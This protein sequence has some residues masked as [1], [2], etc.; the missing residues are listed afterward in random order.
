MFWVGEY[1]YF[2]WIFDFK[3]YLSGEGIIVLR[4]IYKVVLVGV[5]VI[6]YLVVY[7][8]SEFYIGICE[9]N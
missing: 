1:V 3:E 9:V 6:I 4:L 7:L 5:L 2:S 8:L